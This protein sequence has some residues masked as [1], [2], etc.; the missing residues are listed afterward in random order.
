MDKA[1]SAIRSQEKAL[2]T[3][4]KFAL[5]AKRVCEKHGYRLTSAY[6]VGSRARGDYRV[7]SDIDI[8]LVVENI[9][10]LD[11]IDRMKLFSEILFRVR[12]NIDY[13]VYSRREWESEE[14]LWIKELK[15]EAK[16]IL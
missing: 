9:D 1:V 4:R 3:A 10:G 7:D 5:E 14:T 8:V 15:K 16:R 11:V 12:G 6:L 13:R 2:E